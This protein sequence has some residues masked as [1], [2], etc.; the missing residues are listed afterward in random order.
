[1]E[2]SVIGKEEM[3]IVPLELHSWLP[4]FDIEKARKMPETRSPYNFT[5]Q[6][7]EG[8]ELPQFAKLYWLMPGQME[9]VK[10]QIEELEQCRMISPSKSCIAAPLFFVPKKDRTQRMC[11]NY[12][13]LNEITV[14]DA[15]PLP[16]MEALLESARGATVFSKLDLR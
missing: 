15:Y 5:I 16:N 11:I 8:K 9:E 6:L 7:V 3:D 14:K 10:K 1:M 13:A 12:C 2:I 4:G